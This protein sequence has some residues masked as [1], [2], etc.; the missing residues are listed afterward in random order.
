M[1]NLSEHFTE[2]EFIYSDTA[3]K[4]GINNSMDAAHR[5]VAVHTCEYLLEK[6]RALL[7]AHYGCTVIISLN[8]GYRCPQLN[9]KVGGSSTSQHVKA[10]AAD[11]SCYKVK[12]K[13]KIKIPPLEIYN[14]IKT[15]VKQGKISVDQCIYEVA[16]SAVWV[17]VSM[18]SWGA[19]KNRNQFLKYNNGKYTLDTAG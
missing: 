9:V 17:H 18:S 16:G 15:W 2:E 8:S 7:N 5:K 13:V 10:E 6:I 1:A 3:R 19:T 11:L 12:N 14:L 4:Y